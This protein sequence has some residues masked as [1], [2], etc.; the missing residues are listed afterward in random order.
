MSPM[1][2]RAPVTLEGRHVRLVPVNRDQLDGLVRAADDPAIWRFTRQGDLRGA[3]AM[4]R[5]LDAVLEA[6]SKGAILGFTVLVKPELVPVGMTGYVEIQRPD[7]WVEVGGTWY[8]P[9]R[10]R[11]P[12]NS[13]CKLL[14]LTHAFETE[15]CHRV[16]IKTDLRNDRSQ[17]AIARLGAVREG[18]RREHI[19]RLDGGW[20]TSVYFGIVESEWPTVR[21]R[22]EGFLARPWEPAA[23]PD[24][25]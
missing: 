25:H 16:E 21:A 10:W 6:Q 11:T 8:H 15:R 22:L 23:A 18:I 13:E 17:A 5:H 2:F 14:L 12:V 3:E 19:R 4:G 7:A 9:S 24:R 20:R 1:E